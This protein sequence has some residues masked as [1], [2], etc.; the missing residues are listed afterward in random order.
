MNILKKCSMPVLF[1]Q[2]LLFEQLSFTHKA[3]WC[4]AR[5]GSRVA[6]FWT[7]LEQVTSLI[8]RA[9]LRSSA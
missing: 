8:D 4:P 9:L 5:P 6:F 1:Y 2:E 7:Y 3:G